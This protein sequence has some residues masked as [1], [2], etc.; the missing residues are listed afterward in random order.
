VKLR[1]HRPSQVIRTVR[2]RM[3]ARLPAGKQ[4]ATAPFSKLDR[5]SGAH[6]YG[7][8]GRKPPGVTLWYDRRHAGAAYLLP[9]DRPWR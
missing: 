1:Q 9:G 5:L 7:P 8:P 3:R 2:G 4:A 6:S